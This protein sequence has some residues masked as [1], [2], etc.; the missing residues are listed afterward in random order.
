VGSMYFGVVTKGGI[1]HLV[2][3]YESVVILDTYRDPRTSNTGGQRKGMFGELFAASV[4]A[5]G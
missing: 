2:S 4:A 5:I 1:F 3:R